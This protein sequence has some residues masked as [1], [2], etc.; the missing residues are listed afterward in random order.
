MDVTDKVFMKLDHLR[1]QRSGLIR[2][3]KS[4]AHPGVLK[5]YRKRLKDVNKIIREL[6]GSQ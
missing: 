4:I 6:G 5:E 1:I 3:I 2:D